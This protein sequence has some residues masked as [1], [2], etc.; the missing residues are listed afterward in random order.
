MGR[1][2]DFETPKTMTYLK[3]VGQELPEIRASFPI[4]TTFFESKLGN[5]FGQVMP[6]MKGISGVPK[7]KI[8]QTAIDEVLGFIAKLEKKGVHADYRNPD[9]FLYNPTSKQFSIVDLNT[10]PPDGNWFKSVNNLSGSNSSITD[11][12]QYR[13]TGNLKKPIVTLLG[14]NTNNLDSFLSLLKTVK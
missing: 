13:F 2:L 7:E 1:P 8:P 9:N 10:T 11:I 4:S 6:K 5:R 14:P 3:Q 12:L